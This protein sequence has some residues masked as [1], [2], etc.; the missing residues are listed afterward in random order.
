M[1]QPTPN[2]QMVKFKHA[3]ALQK[4]GKV[5]QAISEYRALILIAPKMAEAHFQLARLLI[6]ELEYSKALNHLEVARKYA[7]LEKSV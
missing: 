1:R 7:P 2:P 6:G 3:R 5:K 4:A